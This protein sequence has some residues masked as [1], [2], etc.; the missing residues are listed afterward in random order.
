[1]AMSTAW[2]IKCDFCKAPAPISTVSA[3]DA[4]NL[5]ADAGFRRDQS[6]RHGA[7]R[8]VC[9]PCRDKQ[10]AGEQP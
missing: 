1:M 2:Y 7:V 8:D 4:R 10:P 3:V 5:A 9:L 6:P